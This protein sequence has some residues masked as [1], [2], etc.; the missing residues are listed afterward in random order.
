MEHAERDLSA[1]E[2]VESAAASE[3]TAREPQGL[4]GDYGAI[5][6]VVVRRQPWP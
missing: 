4:E 6:Q 2:Q 3:G 1:G 5:A